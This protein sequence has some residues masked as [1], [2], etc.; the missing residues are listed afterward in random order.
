MKTK[1]RV[2]ANPYTAVD[3]DGIPQGVVGVPLSRG[4][5]VGARIDDE[6]SRETGKTRFVFTGREVEL[7]LIADTARAVLD[8]SLIAAN[9][10]S[11]KACGVREYMAPE[12]ALEREKAR[13]TKAYRALKGSDAELGEIPTVDAPKA[14]ATAETLAQPQKAAPRPS[15]LIALSPTIQLDKREEA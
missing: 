3:A 9:E 13:A 2:L 10:A 12:Q 5:W 14:E 11:A 1:I 4:V 15:A 6:R 8:G 7:P